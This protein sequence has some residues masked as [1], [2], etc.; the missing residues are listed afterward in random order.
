MNPESST[1]ISASFELLGPDNG[2]L[3]IKLQGDWVKYG[4]STTSLS[5]AV[6]E[7]VRNAAEP[8]AEFGKVSRV[9]FDGTDLTK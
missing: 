4:D 6:F 1:Q 5:D 8:G 7:V 3:T 9:G 2:M